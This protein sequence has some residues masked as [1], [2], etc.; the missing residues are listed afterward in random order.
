MSVNL[1]EI[2]SARG[3]DG[4]RALVHEGR[5]VSYGEL[6]TLARRY[7]ARL[8]AAGVGA[9][10]RVA[11]VLANGPDSAAAFFGALWV[12]AIVVP[13]NVLLRPR[14]VAE[15][16]AVAAP[17]AVVFDAPREELAEAAA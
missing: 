3:G 6:E 9:G 11:I 5:D 15:R 8:A 4:A 1:A 12:G 7:A 10:D 13:V 2:V 14:E 17:A 16:L